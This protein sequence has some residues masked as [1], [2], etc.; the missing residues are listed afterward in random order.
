M[1]LYQLQRFYNY[2]VTDVLSVRY[3]F[4]MWNVSVSYLFH[5][6]RQTAHTKKESFNHAFFA[7]VLIRV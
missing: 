5:Q 6:S 3:L 1:L 2:H 4:V 7:S